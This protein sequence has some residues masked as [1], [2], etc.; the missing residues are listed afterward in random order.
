M[1]CFT[2][3]KKEKFLFGF[4]TS[5]ALALSIGSFA[6]GENQ[7]PASPSTSEPQSVA[8]AAQYGDFEVES[9]QGSSTPVFANGVL[10]ISGGTHTISMA[11]EGTSTKQRIEVTG[12]STITLENVDIETSGGAALKIDDNATFDVTILLKDGTTNI[13]KTTKDEC[14]GL[15]KSDDGKITPGKLTI[16]AEG[17]KETGKLEATGGNYGAGIGSV[18]IFDETSSMGYNGSNIE[19]SGGTVTATGGQSGAGIGGGAA[20]EDSGGNGT[21]ITISGGTVT[22]I[23]GSQA[24]GIGGGNSGD[25]TNI[26]ISG[27]YV[28]AT[29]GHPG[30]NE[31]G[32]GIGGGSSKSGNGNKLEGNA[33][34]LA[35]SGSDSSGVTEKEALEG[36][37]NPT[38]GIAFTGVGVYEYNPDTYEYELDHINWDSHGNMHGSSVTI[39]DDVQF[40]ANL[41]VE[42]GKLLTVDS[43]ASLTIAK[44]TELTNNGT[45]IVKNVAT[46]V[47][48][49]TITLGDGAKFNCEGTGVVET[50]LKYDPQGGT[51]VTNEDGYVTYMDS[52]SSEA[53]TY[54]T[55]PSAT[56][57]GCD[58]GGWYTKPEGQGDEVKA[59]SSVLLNQHT[60]YA[61]WT[62]DPGPEPT[63]DPSIDPDGSGGGNSKTGDT[64]AGGVALALLGVAT[65]G[66]IMLRKRK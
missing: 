46:L 64:F 26:T 30:Y 7:T 37:A 25:G 20:G 3:N 53:K 12:A 66:A 47:N 55:L 51:V 48:E 54:E 15:Q 45:V 38:G 50:Q 62:T 8:V 10:T 52:S 14:A 18:C 28:N 34:V 57:Y 6:M 16:G 32:A 11:T 21:N 27:G 29:G 23:G 36:F 42:S 49:G 9:E 24:A 63:P 59:D 43:G 41:T 56:K 17:P 33:V 1:T 58:F 22:A 13:L 60:L 5:L 2:K 31:G 44:G 35:A 19:I 4:A 40:P 65:T 61:N 39:T